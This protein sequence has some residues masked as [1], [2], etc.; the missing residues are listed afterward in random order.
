MDLL[1][2]GCLVSGDC[3]KIVGVYIGNV[4]QILFSMEDINVKWSKWIID[5]VVVLLCMVGFVKMLDDSM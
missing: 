2:D 3:V 5:K 1:C 4:F